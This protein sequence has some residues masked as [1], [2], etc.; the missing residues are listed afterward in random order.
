MGFPGTLSASV[1][2]TLNVAGTLAIDYHAVTDRPTVVNLTN[3]AYF[4]LAGSDQV[5]DHL[6]VI[7]ADHYLPVDAGSIPHGPAEP[8]VGTPFDFT[9]ARP[10]GARIADPDKQLLDSNGYDHCWVLRPGDGLRRAA[11]L[12]D[13]ES[14]RR[15]EVWTTEPGLQVYTGNKL[16]GSLADAAGRRHPRHSAVC[17]ETQHLPNSPNVADYRSTVLRPDQTYVSRTEYRV[18]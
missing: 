8:V 16:D 13:P 10:L 11:R 9:T 6:L 12:S 5:L 14:G 1:T 18:G 3:H 2:Y 4:N 17:L 15:L 7:D